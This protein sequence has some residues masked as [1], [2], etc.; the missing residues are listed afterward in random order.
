[1]ACRCLLHPLV[2]ALV[3]T[4]TL[5]GLFG[6]SVP[7]LAEPLRTAAAYTVH[8]RSTRVDALISNDGLNG[9]VDPHHAPTSL[10]DIDMTSAGHHTGRSFRSSAMRLTLPLR[11]RDFNGPVSVWSERT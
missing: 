11:N 4:N 6:M 9:F 3:C 5:T 2:S 7:L 10:P 1:M 8:M